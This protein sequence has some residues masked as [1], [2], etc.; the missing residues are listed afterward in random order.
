MENGIY[1]VTNAEPR[2]DQSWL[3]NRFTDG[4]R[5]V[6]LD[7]TTFLDDDHETDY[8]ASVSD[9][10]TVSYLKSGIPLARITASG[11]YGPYDP[12]ASDGR[13]TG[14][15]GL[16]ESQLRIEWT[17][18]GLKYKTFSAGMRYMAVIDKSKLPVD[19]GEAVFEGL[20]FDL[21]NGD[22]SAAGGAITPLSAAAGKATA[23]VSVDSVSDA[24][25]T[26]KQLMKAANAD[27]AL[28]AIGITKASKVADPAGE[29]PTKAEFIALRDAI[30][31]TGIMNAS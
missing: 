1:T 6:T 2:D 20:F 17:R 19:T 23:S 18:G 24:G 14:V 3:V 11:K 21:P 27:A 26:G 16:L 29:T 9:T 22:N 8:F 15:A 10:D 7:M 4:V 5:T 13:E 25:T 28:T 12:E 31:S 30:V